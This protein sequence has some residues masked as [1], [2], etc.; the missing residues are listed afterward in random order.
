MKMVRTITYM[1]VMSICKPQRRWMFT[2]VQFG[3]WET[4]HLGLKLLFLL[5]QTQ[6][7]NVPTPCL[8]IPSGFTLTIIEI[9]P[10]T[11]VSG[12]A[13]VSPSCSTQLLIQTGAYWCGDQRGQRLFD[14][15]I[16][17]GDAI[18]VFTTLISEFPRKKSKEGRWRLFPMEKMFFRSGFR[19]TDSSSKFFF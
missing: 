7:E 8:K 16:F 13:D 15:E 5:P 11:V 2:L 1:S 19:S 14:S 10:Q 12:L 18:V 4:A 6:L 3:V 9:L 17:W